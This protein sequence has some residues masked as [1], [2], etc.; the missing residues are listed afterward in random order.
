MNAKLKDYA[1]NW[2]DEK[3]VFKFLN[4]LS[5]LQSDIMHSE[6]ANTYF[7]RNKDNENNLKDKEFFFSAEFESSGIKKIQLLPPMKRNDVGRIMRKFGSD[8]FLHVSGK[9]VLKRNVLGFLS[10]DYKPLWICGRKYRLLWIDKYSSPQIFVFFAEEGMGISQPTEIDEVRRWC[11][12]KSLNQPI[13]L[14]VEDDYLGLNFKKSTYCGRLSLEKVEFIK[15][16]M[17]S[18]NDCEMTYGYGLISRALL[19]SIWIC[20]KKGLTEN[21]NEEIDASILCGNETKCPHSSFQGH[22]GGMIGTWILDPKLKNG[23]ILQCRPSQIKYDTGSETSSC[24][25]DVDVFSWSESSGMAYF[26]SRMI[27]ILE[28]RGVPGKVLKE[29]ASESSFW[30][31][32]SPQVDENKVRY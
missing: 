3:N 19:E 7:D 26:N 18:S 10:N 9:S 27:Q 2:N 15:D 6:E 17:S 30:E 8:R 23:L 5:G 14:S 21:E 24:L 29:E 4:D 12:P 31:H 28:Y 1:W 16:I 20:Y 32:V 25:L 11:M 22:I 13:T